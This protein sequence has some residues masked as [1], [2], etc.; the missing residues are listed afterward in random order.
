MAHCQGKG[1]S[2]TFL[3]PTFGTYRSL[4]H[5]YICEGVPFLCYKL[6]GLLYLS[7]AKRFAPVLV[8]S[9]IRQK[10]KIFEAVVGWGGFRRKGRSMGCGRAIC[11][12][13][14]GNAT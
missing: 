3:F 13:L 5:I 11:L 9:P 2:N 14:V 10:S 4:P 1:A 12:A 7:H 8:P 6:E